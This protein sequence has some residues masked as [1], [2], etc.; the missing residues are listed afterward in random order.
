MANKGF[1]LPG[2][3]GH[4]FDVW[5]VSDSGDYR[6]PTVLTRHMPDD[7]NARVPAFPYISRAAL[8]ADVQAR[9][10][11]PSKINQA[12]SSLCG[13]SSLMYLTA[14]YLPC[15]Y[16]YF[17]EQLYEYGSSR[18]GDLTIEPGTDCKNY[19]PTGV[20]A[21][22]DWVALASIRDSEN[23]IFDYEDPSDEFAGITIPST[24]A[25]WLEKVGFR[26]IENETNLYLTKGEDNLR[27]ANELYKA[28]KEVCL[29]INADILQQAP[30]K[31][32]VIPQ[33]FTT[34]DHWVVMTSEMQLSADSVRF[35]VFSWGNGRYPM[36]LPG[37]V[38][39]M[40]ELLQNYYGYVA[41]KP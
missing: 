36:P 3:L 24:L 32:G 29:F 12:V 14:K 38:M 15:W 28:G 27:K 10:A 5:D 8:Y 33:T 26:D 41:V 19:Q 18:I 23:V 30:K 17:V 35:T 34:P 4:D 7:W 20:I 6:S 31:R 21:A 2:P 22:A 25:G 40:D 11:D 1:R 39:T 9:V 16:A 37:T 13:P